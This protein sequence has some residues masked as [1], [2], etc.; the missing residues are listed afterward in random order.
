MKRILLSMAFAIIL[1]GAA[2][3]QIQQLVD[4][5]NTSNLTT[6][7]N[8]DATPVFTNISNLGI[9][10][11]GSINVPSGST[12]IWTTKVG[13][14]ISGAGDIYTLSA[15][16]KIRENSGYGGLGFSVNNTNEPDSYG[17]P[18][19]GLGMA[20]HG[21]GGMFINNRVQTAVSWPPDLVLGNWYKMILK[22]TAK[23][24]NLY[25]LNFQIWNSD[26]NGVLGTMKT[27]QTLN[28]TSNTQVGGASTLHVYFSAAQNRMDKIDNFN[29][30]LEGGAVFVEAGAP[31][32]LTNSVSA[33]S[34]NTATCGGNVTD[35]RLSAVTA[36]GVCWSTTTGPTTALSTKTSDGTGTGTFSSSVPG[37]T[38]GTTYYVRSYAINSV[39]TSYGAEVSFATA[40]L[41]A[42]LPGGSG[43]SGDPYQ[44]ATQQ[45]LYWIAASDAV[46][47]SPNQTTR[48]GSSA[49]YIQTAN[50][51]A[52]STS[53]WDSGAGWTPIGINVTPFTGTYNGNG[54]TISGLFVNRPG[55]YDI[56]L[57]G[58]I[59]N[60]TI[61][62]LGMIGVQLNGEQRVG[63]LVGLC[64]GGAVITNC[65]STGSLTGVQYIGGLVGF[66]QDGS[67]TGCYSS[68]TVG[69]GPESVPGGLVGYNDGNIAN[70]YATGAVTG[71]NLEGGLVGINGPQG[72]IVKSYATGAVSNENN[73]GGLIGGNA[74]GGAITMCFWD[75]MTT[76]QAFSDGSDETLYGKTTLQMKTNTT[77]LDAGWSSA[78]WNMD[79]GFNNGYPYLK[80]QNPHGS[81]L[82]IQ[83]ASFAASA[84]ANNSVRLSWR[85][86]SEI[87][88]YGFYVQQRLQ[89][90]SLFTEV[91][92]S[93]I[94][95][96]GTTIEPQVYSFT[97]TNAGSVASQY[98][99]KQVDLDGT[100]NYSEPVQVT[101]TTNVKEL[102]PTVFGLQ[103]NYPNPF[104]PSTRIIFSIAEEGPISLRVYDIL[105]SEVASL[106]NENR[107]PGQYT[108]QFNGSRLASGVYMY[109]LR[110]SEG[111]LV[112]RMM[113]SK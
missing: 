83:L 70:C 66:I 9:G 22:V 79:A 98:R 12:D 62:N 15:F 82:P 37:L 106:V 46:V 64:Y 5:D 102:K 77:F 56:G 16:F 24:S 34:F 74:G 110:S 49:H 60:A 103:Q 109:V 81:S 59:T 111:Q 75:V 25:D 10:N 95:G 113:L 97:H 44:I 11:T 84:I 3:A 26:A 38:E 86:I 48:W 92:N 78:I 96:H 23:G 53:S 101:T 100:L 17:S 104:N 52:S 40:A 2:Q 89:S 108:E 14:S 32:V 28:N 58:Y 51:D 19:Y 39:G 61:S 91:P 73:H 88:N 45:N 80:C 99:L 112:G 8:P 90:D 76:G 55:I 57:F 4:F 13:Y 69:T 36:R 94:A 72:T 31:V 107:Q 54:K 29:I 18:V 33:I 105:G 47:A 63:A 35:D 42:T 71:F 1:F 30:S 43:T 65:Y 20:F 93:F 50:I 87:N 68:A 85:T 67:V 27:N 7:F 21:G 41:I 6:L